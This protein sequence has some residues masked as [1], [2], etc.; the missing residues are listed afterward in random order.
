MIKCKKCGIELDEETPQQ[1]GMCIDCF[2]DDWGELV[3]KSPMV[4]PYYFL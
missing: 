3:E 4:S 1:N 2:A